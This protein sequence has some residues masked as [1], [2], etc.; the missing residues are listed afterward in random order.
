MINSSLIR[1][2]GEPQRWLQ[3]K[4]HQIFQKMNI[5]Y[6]PDTHTYVYVSGGM[7]CSFWGKYGVLCF[8]LTT[9]LRLALLSFYQ[10]IRVKDL[11]GKYR[12]SWKV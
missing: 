5:S 2:K 11:L 12:K 10:W 7:K 6:P 1:E 9:V 4:V 3:E 8:L